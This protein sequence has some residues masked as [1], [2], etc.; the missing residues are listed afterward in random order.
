MVYLN[1]HY[2]GL[3]VNKVS[4]SFLQYLDLKIKNKTI[5]SWALAVILHF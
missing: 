2:G 4:V 5:Q 1:A 3:W